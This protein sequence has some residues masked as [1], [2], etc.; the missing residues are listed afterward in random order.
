MNI[1]ILF[2]GSHYLYTEIHV[3]RQ[4][5]CCRVVVQED[6]V[7]VGAQL[8]M[9]AE[10]CPYLI[11]GGLPSRADLANQDLPPNGGQPEPVD[12]RIGIVGAVCDFLLC[13]T[14]RG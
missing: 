3:H 5:P 9:L 8:R 7:A 4:L 6:V 11:Q 12:L 1:S 10:K 14:G 13:A 2:K